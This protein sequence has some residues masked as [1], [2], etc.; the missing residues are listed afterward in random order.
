MLKLLTLFFYVQMSEHNISLIDQKTENI[1]LLLVYPF[2]ADFL[3]SSQGFA[4]YLDL[5][6][7]GVLI[8]CG[9]MIVEYVAEKIRKK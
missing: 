6:L 3:V 5:L 4:H 1:F 7:G 9:K 2:L 8:A